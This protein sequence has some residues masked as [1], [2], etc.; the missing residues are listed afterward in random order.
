[1]RQNHHAANI[2][3]TYVNKFQEAQRNLTILIQEERLQKRIE[4][5]KKKQ[6]RP[7]E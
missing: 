2:L 6:L 1:M 7:Y 4:K 5:S 3:L